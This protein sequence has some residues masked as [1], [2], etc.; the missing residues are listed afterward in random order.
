M[1]NLSMY[2]SL[3]FILA[4]FL[5]CSSWQA[6]TRRAGMG[7]RLNKPAY[8]VQAAEGR[9]AELLEARAKARKAAERQ[10]AVAAALQAGLRADAYALKVGSTLSHRH[11]RV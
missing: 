5:C 6:S 9:A 2:Q 11:F 4:A 7:D 1:V 10:A 8:P 3:R